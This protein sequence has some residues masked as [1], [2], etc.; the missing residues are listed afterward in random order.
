MSRS[1]RKC[2]KIGLA[3]GSHTS[4]KKDKVVANRRIRSAVK[5]AIKN[6]EDVLPLK[7]EVSNRYAFSKDG[8]SYF[9]RL[10]Y[11]SAKDK[12]LYESLKRKK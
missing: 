5:K 12:E 3:A 11:G 7:R 8:K 10:K 9:G 2:A 1:R 6:G 4:D